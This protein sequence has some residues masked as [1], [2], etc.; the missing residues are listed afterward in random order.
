[1]AA[2]PLTR[3]QLLGGG[4][5]LVGAYLGAFAWGH[6]P[7]EQRSSPFLGSAALVTLT[8]VF[9]ALLPEEVECAELV[10]GVDAFLAE[11]DPIL[12]GQLRLA[13]GALEHLGGAG[14]LSF[15]GFSRLPRARRI[16]V[17][18]AWH[19]S[20][21]GTKRQIADAVRRVAL[22]TYY[23]QP[24]SWSAIGYDGPLVQR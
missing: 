4:V 24:I 5:L 18:K 17:L 14:P 16:E 12:G 23:T 7:V 8:A 3:R 10:A 22:F 13:L 11:G 19:G 20:S 15:V 1:M 9:E 21:W 6:R 2:L